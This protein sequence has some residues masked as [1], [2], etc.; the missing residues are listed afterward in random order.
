M[1]VK[2]KLNK[3]RTKMPRNFKINSK[4]SKRASH[5]KRGIKISKRQSGGGDAV[6]E[7]T[8][9]KLTPNQLEAAYKFINTSQPKLEHYYSPQDPGDIDKKIWNP[10]L[11]PRD[12]LE[13]NANLP[14]DDSL[15]E[16]IRIT[17]KN[18]TGLNSIISALK[19]A[20]HTLKPSDKKQVTL[21]EKNSE[22]RKF[23]VEKIRKYI[24]FKETTYLSSPS[25]DFIKY[26]LGSSRILC[27]FTFE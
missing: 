23:F 1:P 10:N 21:N 12:R 9:K 17:N 4:S 20:L 13:V 15:S 3:K 27:Y 16:Y 5:K 11:D 2:R 6:N 8:P 26:I 22:W 7:C 19:R 18:V 14:K 25:T 24:Q